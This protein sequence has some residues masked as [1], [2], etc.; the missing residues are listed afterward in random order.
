MKQNG[1]KTKSDL[2]GYIDKASKG[3]YE[4]LNEDTEVAQQRRKYM[5]S[6]KYLLA[7]AV[8][9]KN[10]TTFGKIQGLTESVEKN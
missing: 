2:V 9:K 1:I 10:P 6:K 5:Q 8:I 7:N 4:P 3:G